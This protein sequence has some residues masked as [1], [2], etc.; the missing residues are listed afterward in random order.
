[1]KGALLVVILSSHALFD[2]SL[3]FLSSQPA[4]MEITT[5]SWEA[6]RIIVMNHQKEISI[7][8]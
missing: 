2:G 6:L 8:M 5:M 4:R 7:T 1:V 3:V